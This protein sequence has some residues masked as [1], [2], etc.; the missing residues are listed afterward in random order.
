MHDWGKVDLPLQE[1]AEKNADGQG[2]G[3]A[4]PRMFSDPVQRPVEQVAD[5]L[6]ADGFDPFGR[7]A[8]D[9]LAQFLGLENFRLRQSEGVGRRVN[10]GPAGGM[11]GVFGG[12]GLF[13]RGW[14]GFL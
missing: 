14:G 2:D 8:A 6:I 7:L 12:F 4:R 5:G 1:S 13:G 3:H 11:T 10:V 9:L